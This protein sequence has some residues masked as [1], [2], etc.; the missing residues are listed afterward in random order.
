MTKAEAVVH[1]ERAYEKYSWIL[2][3][4]PISILF[5]F[6]SG[7]LI[8]GYTNMAPANLVSAGVSS[9]TPSSTLTLLNYFA[10]LNAWS[11]I[12]LSAFVIF[13]TLTSFRKG[14]PW[15]WYAILWVF[16]STLVAGQIEVMSG[17]YYRNSDLTSLLF[18]L[19]IVLGLL[20]PFRKFFP[21]T[22]R[23][24]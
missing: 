2:I 18:D 23:L 17:G 5:V 21:K 14:K 9:S 7:G 24:A 11:T 6:A 22:Q 8:Y 13:V 1:K 10:R 4:I 20:L 19:F 3:I 12:S 15:A 16:A